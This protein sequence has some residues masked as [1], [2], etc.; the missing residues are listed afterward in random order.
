MWETSSAL[1]LVSSGSLPPML[2]SLSS[3]PRCRWSRKHHSMSRKQD[4]GE[5]MGH[6]LYKGKKVVPKDL[7]SLKNSRE[8]SPEFTCS[9]GARG[10]SAGKRALRDPHLEARRDAITQA[11]YG[12][13]AAVAVDDPRAGARM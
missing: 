12:C 6:T 5:R 10:R 3:T 11:S 13:A 4:D 9:G 2:P 7:P 1:F 8:P